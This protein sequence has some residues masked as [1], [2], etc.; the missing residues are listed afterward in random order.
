M[1]A[2]S[3]RF[4]TGIRVSVVVNTYRMIGNEPTDG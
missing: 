2:G 4:V 1:V 3:E